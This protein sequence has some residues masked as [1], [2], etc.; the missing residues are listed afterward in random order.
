MKETLFVNRKR[1]LSLYPHTPFT[2][3][4]QYKGWNEKR[5]C[6]SDCWWEIKHRNGKLLCNWGKTGTRGRA[7]PLEYSLKKALDKLAA[8]LAS[9]YTYDPRTERGASAIPKKNPLA[10]LPSP[11]CNITEIVMESGVWKALDKN[12]NTVTRLPD[13]TARDLRAKLAA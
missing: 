3:R 11:F 7:M 2:I 12:G 4:L 9:G 13:A 6:H 8:K 1:A 10:D 5:K